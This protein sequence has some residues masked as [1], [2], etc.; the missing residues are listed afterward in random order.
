MDQRGDELLWSL[1]RD[2]RIKEEIRDILKWYSVEI[3]KT[4]ADYNKIS[5]LIRSEIFCVPQ[6][7]Q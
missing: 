4:F 5:M 7:E 3:N 2:S 1:D 6:K